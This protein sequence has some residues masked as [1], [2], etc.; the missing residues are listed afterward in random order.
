MRD[1]KVP[2]VFIVDDNLIGNKKAIKPILKRVIEWQKTNRF[3]F[4]FLTEASIDLA[5]DPELM[6]LMADANVGGVFVGVESTNEDSL[7]ETLKLQ[8]VRR[9]GTILEKVRRI[10]DAGMEVFAGMI[11]G[12]DNDDKTVFA[13]H[14]TFAGAA[15]SPLTMVSMLA[16]IPKTPLY[17]RMANEGRLDSNDYTEYGT[18]VTPLNISRR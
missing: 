14:R 15:R 9:G 3:P 18:N 16:A 2:M 17:A 12:F 10:E 8:N 13:A 1:L 7:R 11:V 6:R 5:D 4:S